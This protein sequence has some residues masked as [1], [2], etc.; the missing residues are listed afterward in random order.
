MSSH[1]PVW[2]RPSADGRSLLLTLHVQPNAKLSAFAGRHGDALKVRVAAP[3]VDDRAN[4]ALLEFLCRSLGVSRSALDI[5]H[6]RGSRRK[7]VAVTGDVLQW[8]NHIRR[9]DEHST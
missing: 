8:V 5:V 2:A 7:V 4:Q 6:G 3:A 1:L 9:W